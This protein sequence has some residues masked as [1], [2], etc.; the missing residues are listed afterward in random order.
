VEKER[1]SFEEAL[2]KLESII[3]KLEDPQVSLEESI[4]LYEEGMKLSKLCSDT[5][6]AAE[7]KIQKVN[8][9]QS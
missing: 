8:P 7:L 4:S 9:N 3:R 1:L 6:E 2:S 5:L